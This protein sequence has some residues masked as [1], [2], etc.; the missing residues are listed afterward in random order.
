M[1]VEVV[2]KV[3]GLSDLLTL[4]GSAAGQYAVRITTTADGGVT[5]A[6]DPVTLDLRRAELKVAV[7]GPKLAYLNQDFAWTVVVSNSGDGPVSKLDSLAR[8]I[9]AVRASSA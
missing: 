2:W 4:T 3:E 9:R 5:T 7:T 1:A 6:A 8:P